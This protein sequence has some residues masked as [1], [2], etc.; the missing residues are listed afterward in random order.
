MAETKTV[1]KAN[2][3]WDEM[4][5]IRLPKPRRRNEDNFVIASVNGRVFKIK[6]GEEVEVPAPIAEVLQHSM[7]EEDA[8]DAFIQ[9]KTSK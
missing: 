3:P 9:A 4:V 8:A 7:D 6:K 5:K 1:T 2:N